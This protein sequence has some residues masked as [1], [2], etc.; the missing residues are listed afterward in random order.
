MNKD[1]IILVSQTKIFEFGF[2][3]PNGKIDENNKYLGIWYYNSNPKIVVWVANRDKP[4]SN[5]N[6]TIVIKDGNAQVLGAD[7]SIYWQTNTVA[8]QDP[9]QLCLNDLGN[10][11][12][13]SHERKFVLWQSFDHPTNTL[14]P[15]M[16]VYGSLKLIS[17]RNN[18]SPAQGSAE[19]VLQTGNDSNAN[20]I[21]EGYHQYWDIKTDYSAKIPYA[22][23][24][25][26]DDRT[27]KASLPN[28]TRLVINFTR[29]SGQIQLW[30]RGNS[31]E[32]W[33]LDWVEPKDRCNFHDVCGNFGSCNS[34]YGSPCKCLPG[35]RPNLL[36]EWNSGCY[37][38]GCV[39][40][41]GSPNS[42]TD[43]FLKLPR[44]KVGTVDCSA[45]V[46]SNCEKQCLTDCTCVAYAYGIANCTGMGSSTEKR[47]L[48]WTNLTRL[49]EEFSQGITLFVRVPASDIGSSS[50]NCTPCGA[51]AIP[52]PLSTNRSK[53]GDSMYSNF[54]CNSDTGQVNFS[55]PT[56]TFRVALID[57]DAKTFTVQVMQA[58]GCDS[59][60]S[61]VLPSNSSMPFEYRNCSIIKDNPLVQLGQPFIMVEIGWKVP[62]E[63]SCSASADCHPWPHTS[64]KATKGGTRR[65][66]CGSRFHWDGSNLKCVKAVLHMKILIPCVA[67]P[68]AI[69]FLCGVFFVY[70]HKHRRRI[71]KNEGTIEF[72]GDDSEG[73]DVPF[74]SW[75]IIQAATSNFADAN[76][77]GTGGFGS[78]FR[79][80]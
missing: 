57:P 62:L 23:S 75:G 16:S 3:T 70:N 36:Q 10:L 67:V 15:G 25:L 52:Y 19:F 13:S 76:M 54:H 45:S 56:G 4:L 22:L 5:P 2:F 69:F 31:N 38:G 46:E 7:G 12:L 20:I 71:A 74:F 39:A 18:S 41:S 11:I 21:Q 63:P 26:L 33:V 49:Q 50:R 51:Y 79:V 78:V 68:L 35:F 66:K 6:G 43:T 8:L 53:C 59:R 9:T 24:K 37:I 77:L 80:N 29:S 64:C 47:C 42:F 14:L 65:C 40:K 27:G 44:M 28:N 1:G 48:T 60:N 17:W 73:V 58:N 30:K 61:Y 34:N 32:S 55:T 72:E